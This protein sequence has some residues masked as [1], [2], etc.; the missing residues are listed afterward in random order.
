MQNGSEAAGDETEERTY[1]ESAS[2]TLALARDPVNH[3]GMMTKKVGVV[4]GKT[5]TEA[6]VSTRNI[7]QEGESYRKTRLESPAGR[8]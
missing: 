4:C 5:E 3:Q 2:R 1:R 8:A 6:P 7:Q